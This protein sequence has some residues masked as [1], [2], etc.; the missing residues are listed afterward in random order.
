MLVKKILF[1]SAL[2]VST[3]SFAQTNLDSLYAVWQDK[4]QSDSMRVSAFQVYIWNGS[5]FSQ[6][7]TAIVQS[8][9]L[10][11]FGKNN[12]YPKATALGHNLLGLAYRE[13]SEYTKALA[14]FQKS[15][16]ISRSI[17][18]LKGIAGVKN[19]MGSI[20]RTYGQ[21]SKALDYYSQSNRLFEKIGAKEGMAISTM[22]IGIIYY[23]QEN[24]PK[25]LAY[26]KRSLK[27]KQ[28][29]GNKSAICSV[30]SNIGSIYHEQGDYTK[31]LEYYQKSILMYKEM[32][33]EVNAAVVLGNIGL[34]YKEQGDYAKAMVFYRRSLETLEKIGN[35]LNST[36]IITQI[37][38]LNLQM[39]E[40]KKAL[41][42]CT[43]SLE[44]SEEFGFLDL[45]KE[46]CQCLYETHKALKNGNKA[47]DFLE[48]I[49]V[50]D[51][52]LN[53]KETAAKLQEMEFIKQV[54]KDSLLQEAAALKVS[55][56]HKSEIK[57]KNKT[58]DW[59]LGGGVLALLIAG[60]LYARVRYIRKS[61]AK[62]QVE[63]D[64]SENILLNVFPA[65][66][67]KEL[68]EKGSADAREFDAVSILFTDFKGFTA[69]SEKLSPQELM[70]EIGACFE[71]F[72]GIVHKY[73]IEKIKTIGDAYMA[74]GGL[75]TP[76]DEF[77]KNTVLAGLEMQ[78]FV[79]ERK[80]QNEALNKPAFE[81]RLGIHLGPVV[82]GI[83][84]VKKFAYDVWGDT[85]NTASRMESAGAIGKVN[86]SKDAYE[87][88]KEDPDF[89]FEK[90][91]GV[92]IKGKGTMQMYFV[93]AC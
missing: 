26:Y 44:V 20:Y 74:A 54:E 9:E 42:N 17:G 63:R 67:A 11:A 72:D 14:H 50:I 5:L 33:D 46:A 29:L 36:T 23:Y 34:I 13:K 83:V 56:A 57:N 70:A 4:S 88:L 81:M 87:L 12:N 6:P 22:N 64:L 66:I 55:D 51:D 39:K 86:I 40:F 16:E 32:G 21:Y 8:Q 93:R 48:K 89:C 38:L 59:L 69:A 31:A 68:K 80:I 37:G 84:G 18:D 15:T 10:L 91:D 19:N 7:E 61:K 90:R 27:I 45:Q 77:L 62:L 3:L 30:F 52:S 58:R 25:A 85:V 82:A 35:K 76:T 24:Y 79:G 73:H 49:Q 43:R 53:A 1:F 28:E 78:A 60:T 71:A 41:S 47:L 92:E 75:P 65:D 2:C